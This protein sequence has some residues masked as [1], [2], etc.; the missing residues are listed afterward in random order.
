MSRMALA[1]ST[2]LRR[3]TVGRPGSGFSSPVRSSSVSSQWMKSPV[4]AAVGRG[5]PAG[6]I[7]FARRRRMTCSQVAAL[8][9]TCATSSVSSASPA[10][11]VRRLWQATQ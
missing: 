5:R 4:A 7:A 6:G 2:R 3:C 10:V 1:Y 8:V 11:S 9:S